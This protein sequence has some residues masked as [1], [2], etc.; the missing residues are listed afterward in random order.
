MLSVRAVTPLRYVKD[1]DTLPPAHPVSPSFFHHWEYFMFCALTVIALQLNLEWHRGD[2][3][4]TKLEKLQFL[5]F[6][7]DIPISSGIH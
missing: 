2:G 3:I 6:Y 1:S 5:T 4:S 7:E